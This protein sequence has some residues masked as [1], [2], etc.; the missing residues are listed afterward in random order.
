MNYFER[1]GNELVFRNAGE[2]LSIV[3]WGANSLRVRAAM[4]R[5]IDDPRHALLDPGDSGD[6]EIRIGETSASIRCGGIIAEAE[7]VGEAE[8]IGAPAWAHLT[9]RNAHGEVLLRETNC[10]SVLRRHARRFEPNGGDDWSLT[11]EFDGCEGERIRG[12]GQYQEERIDWKG[13]TLELAQRNSQSSVPFYISSLGYGF[14]WHLPAVGEVT[15]GAN[16]TTWR[17]RAV[18]QMDYWITA[19]DTPAQISLQYARATGFAPMMPECGLGFWQ[20]KLRYW[21]QRQILDVAREYRRRGLP[22][23]VIVC[24]Y[25]HWSRLGDFS[26]DPEFFP[27]PAAMV[28]E[29]EG[30]GIRL[31]VS[32]WPQVALDSARYSE[33]RRLGL[34]VR[35]DKGEQIGLRLLE[36]SMFIDFTNPCARAY[37]WD[38]MRRNYHD[39]GV[40]LF[41]LDLA[42][43]EFGTCDFANYRYHAGPVL[44]IGNLYPKFYSRLF[45]DGQ[46][47]A[48]QTDIV[49]LVR[50]A[51]AGSQRYGALVWSGDVMS[52]WEDFRRQICIGLNM[53]AAGIPW[54][55][56][57]IGGFHDGQVDDPGFHE[58]LVRW[59]Q[60]GA[61]CPVM[62]LHGDRRPAER[63]VRADGTEAPPSGGPNEV[64]SFGEE[65]YAILA[66]YLRRREELRP[67]V[68]ELMREAHERGVPLMRGMYYEFPDDAECRDISDQYMFG[69]RYLVAPVMEPGARTRNVFLPAGCDW[70]NVDTGETLAGG[71]MV[72]A[73]APLETI[74]VFE[75]LS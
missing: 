35:A 31:M 17:A 66:K 21:S 28:R 16:R 39:Q 46:R 57:D 56:T 55:T 43:P 25:F 29:L 69:S 10:G 8:H 74:P 13:C 47:A 59:F 34:L 36:D 18:Q 41:W 48:G 33:F 42:E 70:R 68:R 22:L 20:C 4:M 23:D 30:M 19:G 15:F 61:Y 50:C 73:P 49:N 14:L 53:G 67:Y 11:V 2:T 12:M 3:P 1:K 63:V 58:L 37:V 64:W 54:W 6:V 60:W 44:R 27:D 71:H 40:R 9:F 26:F 7:A 62:R 72:V 45:F 32:V 38:E 65:V 75:R 52:R 24:D 51:W 5:D